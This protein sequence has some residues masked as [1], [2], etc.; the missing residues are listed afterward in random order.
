MKRAALALLVMRVA[1]LCSAS[2]AGPLAATDVALEHQGWPALTQLAKSGALVSAAAIDLD[3][4]L[5]LDQLHGETRLTPASLTKL[6]T[7]AVAL[8]RWPADKMFHTRLVSTADVVD[9]ELRGDLVLLGGGDP[10]LDDESFWGLLAQLRGAGV[11]QVSGRLLVVPTPFGS[12][13]CETQDRCDAE[14]HS[15]RSYNAPLGALGVDYG[16]W[17]VLIRP[18]LPGEAAAVQGCG[19]TR[20][21]IGIDGSIRTVAGTARQTFWLERVTDAGGDRLRVGGDIPV[22]PTQQDYRAMSDPVRGS[23]LLLRQMLRESGVRLDGDVAVDLTPPAATARVLAD[24]EGLALGEQLGRM[25]RYS[26]NYIADVLTLDVAADLG[27]TPGTL[28]GAAQSLATFVS[29]LAPGSAVPPLLRSG[30]GLTPENALSADDLIAVLAHV[31]RDPRRF[32]AYYGGLVVPRDAPFGFLREGDEAWLDRV[33]LKTGS[34][35]APHSVLGIAGYLRK[36]DGGWM[37]FAA[38]V[39]GG[40]ARPHV[41]LREALAAARSDVEALLRRY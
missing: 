11:R 38:I 14:R 7:A 13:A 21:P 35:D 3:H 12:V 32:P 17:C 30:S 27:G 39:N 29:G 18:A 10:S 19:V 15:D 20:L 24:V 16:N 23:G 2:L 40:E 8:G 36:R 1:V 25:L 31:Y 26:N 34:M 28:S 41:P 22:G 6:V 4:H 37:A 9:G 5:M 33:A